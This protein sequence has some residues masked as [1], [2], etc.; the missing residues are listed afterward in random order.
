MCETRLLKSVSAGLAVLVATF[1]GISAMAETVVIPAGETWKLGETEHTISADDDLVLRGTLDLNGHD[2]TVLSLSCL[3]EEHMKPAQ[4]DYHLAST[5]CMITNSAD[6]AATF[7]VHGGSTYFTGY[8]APS[9]NFVCDGGDAQ[10]FA[11]DGAFAPAKLTVNK[12]TFMAF[13][14]PTAVVFHFKDVAATGDCETGS[15]NKWLRLSELMITYRG[16]PIVQYGRPIT[17]DQDKKKDNWFN[18]AIPDD[19]FWSTSKALPDSPLLLSIAIGSAGNESSTGCAAVDG[20]RIGTA[21]EPAFAPKTWDVYFVRN[22]NTGLILVDRHVDDSL[23]RP[24]INTSIVEDHWSHNLSQ[25]FGFN[26]FKLGSPLGRNT[27]IELAKGAQLRVSTVEPCAVGAISGAGTIRI[28]DGTTLQPQTLR[29]WTGTFQTYYCQTPAREAK[30]VVSAGEP[31]NSAFANTNIVL[32][33]GTSGGLVLDG[34]GVVKDAQ[35]KDGASPLGIEISAGS[36]EQVLA[37]AGAAYSGETKVNSGMLR[38]QGAFSEVTAKLIR[39]APKKVP[40]AGDYYNYHWG[41]GE[42]KVYAADGSEVSLAGATFSCSTGVDKMHSDSKKG[43][44]LIDGDV[45]TRMMPKDPADGSMATV[46]LELPSPVTFASYAWYPE[47]TTY[48]FPLEMELSV[49]ADGENWILVDYRTLQS[50][51]TLA[52]WQGPFALDG[53]A[54]SNV[55][56]TIPSAYVGAST[57][58][59]G[60]VQ[61]L[62]AKNLRFRP[63]ETFFDGKFYGQYDYGWQVSEFSLVKDGEIV[64]WPAKTKVYLGGMNMTTKSSGNDLA[65][66][67]DNIHTG[68]VGTVDDAH[69]CFC[70]QPGGVVSVDAGEVLEFDAYELWNG[71]SSVRRMPRA[72]SIEISLDGESW[73]FLDNHGPSANDVCPSEYGKYGPFSLKDRWVVNGVNNAIGDKSTVNVAANA[74]VRF[75]TSSERIGGLAGAGSVQLVDTRLALNAESRPTFSGAVTG[76]GKLVLDTGVQTFDGADLTGVS[77][78]SFAGGAFAGTATFGKLTVTG[79]VKLAL[80]DDIVE[81]GGRVTLFTYDSIDASGSN[82]AT[83]TLVPPPTKKRNVEVT[84]GEKSTVVTVSKRGLLLFV[85]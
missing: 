44:S 79:D 23:N 15:T 11:G 29:D 27:D 54:M 80:S 37:T 21:T 20:Y 61:T 65:H 10:V 51:S 25:D 14:R 83:A 45:S 46:T 71:P 7:T 74:A 60:L 58:G 2:L 38:V 55:R 77:E 70:D 75:E 16:V 40:L 59:E 22:A 82:L 36:G 64:P 50:P 41:L 68:G 66:F 56:K 81:N 63:Y 78:L 35:L 32:V 69:R 53:A 8:V 39:L 42:F 13:S 31:W 18:L 28:D 76:S 3:C 12:S 73:Y 48:R 17:V 34:S 52:A 1:C 33:G 47:K 84:I 19:Q 24:S 6:T 43:A 67:A 62:K 30:V 9:V 72:W 26:C 5:D 49:S 85:R 4:F 57:K